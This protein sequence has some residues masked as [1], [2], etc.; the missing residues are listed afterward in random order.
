MVFSTPACV[1]TCEKSPA[2]SAAVGTLKR[3]NAP[4]LLMFRSYSPKINV[5]FFMIGPPSEPP[6]WCICKGA[7]LAPDRL[8]KKLLAFRALLRR[9]SKALPCRCC[10]YPTS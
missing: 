1:Y 2:R 5:L 8:E 4:A 7:I 9:N 6:N 10:L 3:L